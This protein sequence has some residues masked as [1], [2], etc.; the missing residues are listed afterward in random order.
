[1]TNRNTYAAAM[2]TFDVLNEEIYLH[3]E[4]HTEYDKDD[5][6]RRVDE[7]GKML[8]ELLC[9]IIDGITTATKEEIETI[10]SLFYRFE[11]CYGFSNDPY[12]VD[13]L[14]E[15]YGNLSYNYGYY[16]ELLKKLGEDG[17]NLLYY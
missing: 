10:N 16:D 12:D 6:D 15:E 7:S 2:N 17:L 5:L 3:N 14:K 11:A 8:Y 4:G 1:M 13:D 9:E